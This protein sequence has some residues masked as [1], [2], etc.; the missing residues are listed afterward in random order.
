MGREKGPGGSIGHITWAGS[1]FGLR[2]FATH[3]DHWA[4]ERIL[5]LTNTTGRAG[6]MPIL[7]L[8]ENHHAAIHRRAGIAAI[9]RDHRLEIAIDE[10]GS[11]Q[12]RCVAGA[13]L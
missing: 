12:A 9:L 10:N 2:K 13:S 1:L 4:M 5:N 7:P 8:V 11:V 6:T 3:D